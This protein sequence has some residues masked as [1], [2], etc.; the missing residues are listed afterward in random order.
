MNLGKRRIKNSDLVVCFEG[1]GFSHVSAFLASGN[2][3]FEGSG[4]A[5][6]LEGRIE[7]ELKAA[8]IYEVPTFLRSEKELRAIAQATPFAARKGK[9]PGGKLQ[10]ALLKGAP[11]RSAASA[12]RAFEAQGDWLALLGR[13]MYWWPQG[14]ISESE[15]DWKGLDKLLGDMTIRTHRTIDRLVAKC[16][17]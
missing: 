11:S 9:V 14:G 6:V 8:L 12:L 17:S 15:I 5:S 2:V 16:F 7:R 3:A 4:K 10:V 13:E 1:M